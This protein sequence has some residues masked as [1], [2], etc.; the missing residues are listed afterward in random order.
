MRRVRPPLPSRER[1]G[2]RGPAR[3]A[4]PAPGSEPSRA[5]ETPQPPSF[6]SHSAVIPVPP[7]RHSGESRNPA[8]APAVR[9]PGA[10]R[11]N[12]RSRSQQRLA[13]PLTPTL[14]P[15]RGGRTEGATTRRG[16]SQVRMRLPHPPPS[17]A[18]RGDRTASS[19][20]RCALGCRAAGVGPWG[21]WGRSPHRKKIRGWVGGPSAAQRA[22]SGMGAWGAQPPTPDKRGAP[23]V[24]CRS[25]IRRAPHPQGV[26]GTPPTKHGSPPGEGAGRVSCAGA[27]GVV[28]AAWRWGRCR[29]ATRGRRPRRG[30]GRRRRRSSRRCPCR[31]RA[32]G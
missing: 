9:A 4:A 27:S 24:R 6:L 13:S 16:G 20:L 23:E 21:V 25:D 1:A 26:W 32:A 30:G 19:G 15:R 18:G 11:R 5:Q 28:V 17:P 12:N 2:V 7:S 8:G 31:A 3:S 22:L 14:S 29:A 10:P